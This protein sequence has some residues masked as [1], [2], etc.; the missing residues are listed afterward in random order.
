MRERKRKET[1]KP[2][3]K[4][5]LSLF[6]KEEWG[7]GVVFDGGGWGDGEDVVLRELSI[8]SEM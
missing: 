3:H 6:L 8:V 5:F 2:Q 1:W 4:E 7:N